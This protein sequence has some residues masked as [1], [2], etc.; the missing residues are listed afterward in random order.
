MPRHA[1]TRCWV[2]LV[3]GTWRRRPVLD[4]PLR[5]RLHAFLAAC[6]R[7]AGL[8]VRAHFVNPDHV[9]VLLDLPSSRSI[10]D[11]VK[12]LKGSSARWINAEGL[13]PGETFRWAR[14]YGAFSVSHSALPAVARY[15]ADQE[16]HHETLRY[17]EEVRAL[18]GE[19]A[20]LPPPPRR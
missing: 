20:A 9:H 7:D 15:I 1:Y 14:G 10:A 12:Q 13:V 18:L 19:H 4:R 3:W 11:V 17:E 16:A 8:Y 6:A 2:H 5:P